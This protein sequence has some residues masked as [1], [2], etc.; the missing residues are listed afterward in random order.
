MATGQE[1]FAACA[2]DNLCV[3]LKF[4]TENKGNSNWV[5]GMF[6]RGHAPRP[7]AMLHLAC[8]AWC[9]VLS[10]MRLAHILHFVQR[11]PW[12]AAG[13][14]RTTHVQRTVPGPGTMLPLQH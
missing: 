10:A 11:I 13:R 7:S 5:E 4:L 12:G 3:G 2:Y 8:I 14:M 9:P 1:P 6:R